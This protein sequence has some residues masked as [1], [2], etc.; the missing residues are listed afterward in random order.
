MKRNSMPG[1][2]HEMDFHL[3]YFV[4]VCQT[5]AFGLYINTSFSYELK[6]TQC[7]HLTFHDQIRIEKIKGSSHFKESN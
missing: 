7:I 5:C 2:F 3:N 4:R 6:V 1:Y